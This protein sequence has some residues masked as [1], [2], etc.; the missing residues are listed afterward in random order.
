KVMF[1]AAMTKPAFERAVRDL[2]H[3]QWVHTNTAGFDWVLVPG[4]DP[5]KVI[6]TRSP[7]SFSIAIGEFVIGLMFL[8]AKRFPAMLKAK[9]DRVWLEPDP[10]EL[11]GKTVGIV[12]AGAIGRE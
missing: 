3:L 12:G 7:N 1:R 10:D 5:Y 8:V 9:R 6:L 2:P 4:V 11:G